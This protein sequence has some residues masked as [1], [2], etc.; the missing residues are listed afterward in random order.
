MAFESIPGAD[1]LE[2]GQAAGKAGRQL[3]GE[4]GVDRRQFGVAQGGPVLDEVE[5]RIELA[6]RRAEVAW[7]HRRG[8]EQCLHGAKVPQVDP[9][10]S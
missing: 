10:V 5:R 1:P 8:D 6:D 2:P 9:G 3:P 7:R 4:H